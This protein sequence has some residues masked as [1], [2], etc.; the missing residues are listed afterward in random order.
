MSQRKQEIIVL[1]PPIS[2][3]G[4]QAELLAKTL[5]VAHISVG[6]LLHDL[7]DNNNY[8]DHLKIR[9]CLDRGEL[10]PHD[11]VN[12]LVVKRAKLK[13]CRRGFILDGYPRAMA[14]V[15]FIERKMKINLVFLIKLSDQEVLRRATGRRVCPLGHIWHTKFNPPKKV[16]VCDICGG[17]LMKRRD[18]RSTVVRDRLKLY[19]QEMD[20]IISFY[21]KQKKLIIINGDKHIDQVFQSVMRRLV[22]GN[23]S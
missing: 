19:H 2:G 16:G 7:A 10:V 23:N 14:Q 20:P 8:A 3:K 5:G 15:D 1:G 18:D 11:L 13:D 22:G 9:R 12:S 6:R 21:K 4:T 17:R